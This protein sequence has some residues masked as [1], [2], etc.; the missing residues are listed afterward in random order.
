MVWCRLKT[1]R[2]IQTDN[3]IDD[4]G[5]AALGKALATNTA[6]TMLNLS[7]TRI[8]DAGAKALSDALRTN[9]TLTHLDL[10]CEHSS[11]APEIA[12]AIEVQNCGEE[13]Q[14]TWPSAR[15]GC[16]A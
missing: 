3:S 1:T 14:S 13:A 12:A 8:A 7:G 11:T 5:A 9:T 15:R 2:H 4:S 16:A 6:L 10:S